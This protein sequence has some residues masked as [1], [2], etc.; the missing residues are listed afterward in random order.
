MR[1]DR[2]V[3]PSN[4]LIRLLVLE[5]AEATLGV[6]DADEDRAGVVGKEEDL[7]VADDDTILLAGVVGI[8]ILDSS[9]AVGRRDSRRERRCASRSRLKSIRRSQGTIVI[10]I[11]RLRRGGAVSS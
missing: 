2:G 11:D 1:E 4:A 8:E 5:L 6:D 7:G 10:L 9:T 3:A